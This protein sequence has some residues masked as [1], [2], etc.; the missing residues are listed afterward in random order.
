VNCST[1]FGEKRPAKSAW[2]QLKWVETSIFRLLLHTIN[3]PRRNNE[4]P[5]EVLAFRKTL[6]LS[7]SGDVNRVRKLNPV[8][9]VCVL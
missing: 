9:E 4:L 5:R 2:Q 1:K 8:L 7:S 6:S 3:I